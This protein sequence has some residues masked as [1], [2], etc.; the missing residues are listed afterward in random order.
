MKSAKKGITRFGVAL[1]TPLLKKF[2]AL[3]KKLPHTN[4]SKAISDLVRERMG[5]E[6]LENPGQEVVG[7]ITLIYDHHKR[8]LDDTLVEIQ[9]HHLGLVKSSMHLHLDSEHCLEILALMG[10]A[11]AI[12]D[13]YTTLAGLKGVKHFSLSLAPYDKLV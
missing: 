13:L 10:T 4:R 9:H 1:E 3:L 2:D 12:R 7:V 8:T 6:V 11:R 5:R